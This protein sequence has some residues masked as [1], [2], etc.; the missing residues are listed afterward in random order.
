MRGGLGH[1]VKMV[2][3]GGYSS[4]IMKKERVRMQHRGDGR[5]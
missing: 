5:K 4:G 2:A 3:S 1:N